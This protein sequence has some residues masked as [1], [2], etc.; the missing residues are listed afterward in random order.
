LVFTL[1][2][3]CQERPVVEAP[4]F[5][6]PVFEWASREVRL[7]VRE[8]GAAQEEAHHHLVDRRR[9]ILANYFD[10]IPNAV[11]ALRT[12]VPES[13]EADSE[14]LG[15]LT[16]AIVGARLASFEVIS[17]LPAVGMLHTEVFERSENILTGL[18]LLEQS[19]IA[20]RPSH[21][22]E[23]FMLSYRHVIDDYNGW[24]ERATPAIGTLNGQLLQSGRPVANRRGALENWTRRLETVC[25]EGVSANR[26]RREPDTPT[27]YYHSWFAE[28]SAES[29]ISDCS[30]ELSALIEEFEVCRIAATGARMDRDE[31]RAVL[32][33]IEGARSA[34][35]DCLCAAP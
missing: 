6:P 1:G 3:S 11:E 16:V 21:D 12:D 23:L 14:R 30:A 28:A 15:T 32:D 34:V 24:V 13:R 33:A 25:R 31:G 19:V 18:E 20:R 4:P 2:G 35:G 5:D 10:G 29:R 7:A 9:R 22:L 26:N 8:G 17:S 27:L